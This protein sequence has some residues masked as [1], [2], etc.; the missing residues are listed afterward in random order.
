MH[1]KIAPSD[2]SSVRLN[3]NVIKL[4]TKIADARARA[5]DNER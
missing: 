2:A 1:E 5:R 4:A 3:I